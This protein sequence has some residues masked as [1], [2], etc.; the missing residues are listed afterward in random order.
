MKN[1]NIY[2]SDSNKVLAG[3]CGGIGEYLEIDP[4][5]IRILFVIATI[6]GFGSPIFLYFVLLFIIPDRP[7]NMPQNAE[8][9]TFRDAEKP[10]KGPV[11]RL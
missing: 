6:I 4:T 9:A 5:T 10:R 1:K 8:D 11:E 3:I 7:K 2:T